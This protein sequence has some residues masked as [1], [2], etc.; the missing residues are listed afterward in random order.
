[1]HP[2]LFRPHPDCGECVKALVNCHKDNPYSKFWGA[3][4]DVKAAMDKCFRDEKIA[5]RDA[6]L[7]KAMEEDARWRKKL[8]EDRASRSAVA[9]HGTSGQ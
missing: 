9:S 8:A 1:M 4:N 2:P 3:C 7:E 6:N 5:R